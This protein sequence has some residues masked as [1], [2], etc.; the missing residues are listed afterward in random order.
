MNLTHIKTIGIAG[1]GTM[2]QGIAQVC[3]QA[4][5]GVL[6]YDVTPELIEGGIQSIN[7][8]LT[9]LVEKNK[10]TSENKQR[11]LTRLKAEPDLKKLKAD[12]IIEAVVEN[13]EV[14]QHLI[15]TVEEANESQC[16]LATNT[17]SISITHLAS[18]LKQPGRF[19]GLHFFNPAPVMKL[20]EIIR[21]IATSN[22]TMHQ[23][24]AFSEKLGKV[25]V[26][27]N[28]SPGFIVN[29][30]ARHY[31]VEALKILEENVSDCTTTD[32]LMKA[33]GFKMGPFELMDLIGIDTNFA[34]T[35]SIYHAF[36]QDPKFRPSRIQHQKVNAGHFGR[37]SGKG[38]YDYEK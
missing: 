29:R 11:V 35:T 31:Y 1:A 25:P 8:S 9:A 10:L 33:S 23:L 22:E 14:K 20:V 27:V 2:G 30:I 38:F 16:L 3:L 19:A 13:P 6:L 5:Y 28:D 15:K 24:A 37:K 7:R 4:G 34:V 12:L 36:H 26:A 32:A 18:A 17:S 21:G